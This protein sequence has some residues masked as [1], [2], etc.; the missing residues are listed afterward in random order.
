MPERESGSTH[1]G[2]LGE[3]SSVFIKLVTDVVY[4]SVPAAA[5]GVVVWLAYDAFTVNAEAGARS[6]CAALLPVLL[7][8]Y[9]RWI[10]SDWLKILDRLP[11]VGLALGAAVATIAVLTVI[12][13]GPGSRVV[14]Q[15]AIT[16][17]FC[18]MLIART[19]ITD[20]TAPPG[21]HDIKLLHMFFGV[22][23]ALCLYGLF[24]L[25]G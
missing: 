14:P 8:C 10:R 5:V 22:A 21:D 15:F 13:A 3:Q 1:G 20:R 6:L 11:D 12:S 19:D 7:A 9:I 4:W 18:T 16:F 2:S 23:I 24:R 17:A 25:E